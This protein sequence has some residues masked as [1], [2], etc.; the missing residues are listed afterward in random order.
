[1]LTQRKSQ[2][3]R[4]FGYLVLIS[5]D[6]EDITSPFTPQFLFR[7]RRYNKHLSQCFTGYLSILNFT[8]NTPLHVIFQL[9][10]RCLDIPMKHR[11]LCLIYYIKMYLVKVLVFFC[12]DFFGVLQSV[13]SMSW[14]AGSVKELSKSSL[15]LCLFS[16]PS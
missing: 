12:L 9:T 4:R 16:F 8:K 13:C 3:Q 10:S 11:F 1:M 7:L 6:F 14:L 2:P 15:Q 5:V